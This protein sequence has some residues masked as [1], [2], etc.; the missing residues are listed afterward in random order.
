MTK[1]KILLFLLL[2]FVV[3]AFIGI[4][5]PNLNIE[6]QKQMIAFIADFSQSGLFNIV[7]PIAVL[8]VAIYV[9]IYGQ[10]PRNLSGVRKILLLW[11]PNVALGCTVP[12][13]TALIGFLIAYNGELETAKLTVI[14]VFAFVYSVVFFVGMLLPAFEGV[15]PKSV[16][17]KRKVYALLVVSLGV[18]TLWQYLT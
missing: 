10:I 1:L 3:G 7:A 14:T 12:F 5:F 4:R 9:F 8:I 18:A 11:L 17:D 13:F 6:Q 16:A 2:P 15:Y